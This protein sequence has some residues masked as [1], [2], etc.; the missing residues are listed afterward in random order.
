MVFKHADGIVLTAIFPGHYL[1]LIRRVRTSLIALVP[2]SEGI[3]AT[4]ANT[5]ISRVVVG[6]E[7]FQTA[8]IRRDPEMVALTPPPSA[9]PASSTWTA[10]PRCTCR[11]KATG[12]T[13]P[14][15]Y[16]YPGRPNR[17]N[18]VTL[19]DVLVSIDFLALHNADYSQEVMQRLKPTIQARARVSA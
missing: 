9:V 2:A 1:R 12:S 7:I 17:F 14:G 19:A 15:N 13:A 16:E 5:G 4:L 6:P 18:F 11:S 3:H 10:R 8:A